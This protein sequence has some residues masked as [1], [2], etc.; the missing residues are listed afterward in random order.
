MTSLIRL[1]TELETKYSKIWGELKVRFTNRH[2]LKPGT[3]Y[4]QSLQ[5]SSTPSP[6]EE[7]SVGGLTFYASEVPTI[8]L[9]SGM[10]PEAES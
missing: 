10:T 5:S 4:F 9:L 3:A 1:D 7:L 8:E 6:A 2:F